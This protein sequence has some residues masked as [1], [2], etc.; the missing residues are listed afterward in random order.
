VKTMNK[1]RAGCFAI[2]IIGFLSAAS[3]VQGTK[4]VNADYIQE[5]PLIKNFEA[6][7][8]EA[9]ASAFPGPFGQ[10]Q[11]PK[12]VHLPGY[13]Y[14]FMFQV[15]IRRGMI[16]TPF[17]AYPNDADIAPEQKRQRIEGLRDKLVRLLIIQGSRM[18]PLQRNESIAIV[19]FF[20]ETN[21]VSP[22][23]NLNKTLILS[24]LKSDL[25]DLANKQE[26]LNELL[27]RVKIVE[28]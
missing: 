19:A 8:S 12:G 26:R 11:K 25:D 20:D 9:I 7:I 6:A 18:T 17:G 10:V 15:N 5:R 27:Q 24:V 4:G 28:Y 14:T 1:K 13:G 21:P 22:D 23:E 2:L 16:N 3:A